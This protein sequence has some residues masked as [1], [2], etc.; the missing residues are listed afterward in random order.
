MSGRLRIAIPLAWASLGIIP[1]N[2]YVFFGTAAPAYVFV[3]LALLQFIGGGTAAILAVVHASRSREH[4][5][6]AV[7]AAIVGA[8]AGLG[9]AVALLL[10]WLVGVIFSHARFN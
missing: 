6:V 5:A 2:V 7:I 9:A 3:A 4:R 10:F 8:V 1:L